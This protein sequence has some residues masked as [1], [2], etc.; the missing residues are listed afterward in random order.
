MPR[1]RARWA[2]PVAAAAAASVIA[3]GLA[4]CT[5]SNGSRPDDPAA[6]DYVLQG[7]VQR[8]SAQDGVWPERKLADLVPSHRFRMNGATAR[9]L[10]DGI[11]VGTVVSA[12]PGRGYTVTASDAAGGTE[13]AF[14]STSALWRVL[15]LT[16]K[17]DTRLGDVGGRKIKVGVVIDGGMN[18]DEAAAG[19]LGLGRVALVLNKQ[20]AFG[21]DPDLYSVR[22]SGSLFGLVS[23]SGAISFPALA[24]QSADF[25]GS[26]DTVAEVVDESVQSAPVVDVTSEGAEFARSDDK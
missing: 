8:A 3:L 21:F 17:T 22:E 10:A 9:P 19:Y 20:G 12:D 6:R 4:G 26:L 24:G 13:V 23:T 18:T 2:V 15:V 1:T 14:E 16:I 11:V 5:V 25:V 7:M